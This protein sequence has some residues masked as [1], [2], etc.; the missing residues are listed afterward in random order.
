MREGSA[1]RKSRDYSKRRKYY[2]KE[3]ILVIRPGEVKFHDLDIDQ[4]P[5]SAAG[6]IAQDSCVLIAQAVTESARIGRKITVTQLGWRFDVKLPTTTVGT[7]TSDVVRLILY[8][9]KQA[10]GAA[11]TVTDILE[12]ADYQSFNNL[13]N[14]GRF[15]TLM[16]KTYHISSPSGSG[17]GSTDTL[18]FGEAETGGSFFKRLNIPVEY[19]STAGAITELTTNNIGVLVLAVAGKASLLSKMRIR[20]TDG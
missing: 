18:Q 17:R 4:V 1:K 12:S 3:K 10:N 7:D 15:K 19:N 14:S 8:W 9:D 2:P 13:S 20:F 6:T 11:A 5:I 16:D